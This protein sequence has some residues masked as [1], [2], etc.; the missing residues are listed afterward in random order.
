M[1]SSKINSIVDE[2]A[3]FMERADETQLVEK[4]DWLHEYLQDETI[5]DKNRSEKE[6][7]N[8]ILGFFIIQIDEERKT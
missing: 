2:I 8:A 7:M 3:A 6:L 1:D 4:S 5:S